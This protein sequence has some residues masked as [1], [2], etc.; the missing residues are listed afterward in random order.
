MNPS[1]RLSGILLPLFSVRARTDFGVGDFGSLGGFFAWLQSSGQQLWMMPPLLPTA[2]GDPSPYSTCS[3]FGLNPLFIDLGPL[4]AR[5]GVTLTSDERGRLEQARLA[6]TVRYDLVIPLKSALLKR[7]FDAF[8]KNPEPGF[9]AFCADERAW[10]D[11]FALFA[12]ISEEHQRRPWWEWPDGLAERAPGSLAA[13]RQRL[14]RPIRFA[15]WQQWVAEV[16]WRQVRQLAKDHGVLVCGDEPFIIGKDSSDCWSHPDCLRRDGRLGVPPDEFTADGQDWGLPWFDF[17]AMEADEYRWLKFR[18]VRAAGTYDL[19]RI[20]HAVGYFRQYVRDE[21]TPRGRFIP[22]EEDAQRKLGERNFRLLSEA[23]PPPQGLASAIIAEDLG[24]IPRFVHQVLEQLKLPGYKVMRWAREDGVYQHPHQYPA[25]SLVTTGTHDTDTL[26]G[27]WQS[28]QP[29]ERE[30]VCR[31]FPE[32]QQ[33]SAPPAEFSPEL[34]GALLKAA[35]NSSSALCVLP[36]QDV[37]GEAERVNLPGS[38]SDANWSYRMKPEV[39]ELLSRE[40]TVRT[41]LWLER[42]TTESRRGVGG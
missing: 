32:L 19:R 3:A 39:E 6:P 14:A 16:Q 15:Q 27:W 30:A 36:W 11:S 7:L 37:F 28:S 1:G 34:H 35:L 33:F 5:S 18:A 25:V 10:L 20:D 2:A 17:A 22:S 13:A 29:W 42:L 40:D 26:R 4:L 23:A 12:A 41:A 24:V 38:I 21:Q 8:E 31:T 9:E